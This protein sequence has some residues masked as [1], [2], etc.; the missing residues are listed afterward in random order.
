[1]A[2]KPTPLAPIATNEQTHSE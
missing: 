1:M 2:I